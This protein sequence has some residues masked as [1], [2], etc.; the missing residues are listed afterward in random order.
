ML[1][2]IEGEERVRLEHQRAS[3]VEH[4]QHPG[5]EL[6]GVPAR[7][8]ARQRISVGREIVDPKD[9]EPSAPGNDL[10]PRAPLAPCT[11]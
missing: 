2:L 7:E 3:H 1:P 6:G 8:G 10:T 11:A 9:V 5:A 4:I